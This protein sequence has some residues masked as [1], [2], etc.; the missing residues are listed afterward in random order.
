MVLT[1][2]AAIESRPLQLEQL[3]VPQPGPG[4]IRLRVLA[5]G[6]CHTDLHI[7]E[8]DL[9][10]H[11]SPLIP[12]HQIVGAVDALGVGAT[13]FRIGDRVG[14]P[15]LGWIDGTCH[16]C[17]CG[18]ENLCP[19]ARF[20]GWDVQG[21]YA[22]YALAAADFAL[23]LSASMDP[24]HTAPLLCAGIIG[25]RALRLS[26]V[27]RGERL[28][29]IGFGGSGHI[30]LQVAAHLGCEVS[31]FTRSEAHREVARGLGA[32]WAGGIQSARNGNFDGAILFAPAG[33]LV[34]HGLKLLRPGGTLVLAGITMTDL[35]PVPYELL[36]GERVLRTV[37]NST[38]ADA[39]KLLA[40]ATEIPIRTEVAVFPLE[41]ANEALSDLKQSHLRAA[42]VLTPRESATA[43]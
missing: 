17:S 22:E 20:T 13:R 32:F 40:L 3:P 5:C 23:P 2:A 12:G 35:P 1:A 15:W 4:E 25:Y 7:V 36:Y 29:L 10:L 41:S 42:A 16:F 30:A 24:E 28:A 21:G 33:S 37:A 38:R 11:R 19:A 8:G 26:G 31:V 39:Q 18:Q 43:P 6:V 9:A 14:V 34:P 27:R